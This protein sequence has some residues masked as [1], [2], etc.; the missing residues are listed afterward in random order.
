MS[1]GSSPVDP[2]ERLLWR[3]ERTEGDIVCDILDTNSMP[4]YDETDQTNRGGFLRC[5]RLFSAANL[6]RH[7]RES[8][9][10]RAARTG[11]RA[12]RGREV[13]SEA[14]FEG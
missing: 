12:P 6:R 7:L 13:I 3:G 1:R 14:S 9:E 11:W 8:R 4:C 2:A 5:F 10:H